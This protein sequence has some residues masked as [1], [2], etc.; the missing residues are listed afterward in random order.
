MIWSTGLGVGKSPVADG[1]PASSPD[2]VADAGRLFCNLGTITYAGL[3][4]DFVG[5]YQVNVRLASNLPSGNNR[6][7]LSEWGFAGVAGFEYDASA[8]AVMLP[9]Q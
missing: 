1:S 6:L 3:A 2:P 7:W 4:Q 8:N 9:V 5:L